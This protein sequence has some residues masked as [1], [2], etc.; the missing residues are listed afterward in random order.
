MAAPNHPYDKHGMELLCRAF[1]AMESEEE[2]RCFL[3]DLM[4]IREL[5]D[6]TQR[7]CV[8]ERL[9][10]GKAYQKIMEEVSVSS[11]TISRVNRCL[12]YGQGGYRSVLERF[13]KEDGHEAE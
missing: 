13:L 2:C 10:E 4:T 6:M 7:L 11:A 9:Y 1:V 8:A 3:E 5:Q 12:H